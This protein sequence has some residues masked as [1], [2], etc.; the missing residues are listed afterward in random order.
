MN[1]FDLARKNIA[2]SELWRP[3]CSEIVPRYADQLWLDKNE[4]TDPDLLALSKKLLRNLPED[5]IYTYPELAGLYKKLSLWVTQNAGVNVGIDQI[6]LSA[7]S[8]GSIRSVFEAFIDPSDLVLLTSPTFA[9]YAIYS[10]MYGAKAHLIEYQ[11][12]ETNVEN[13]VTV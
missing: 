4:N 12:S 1:I 2:S 9:M 13:N 3:R 6:V 8:D 11:R 5:A 7:G 10:Q